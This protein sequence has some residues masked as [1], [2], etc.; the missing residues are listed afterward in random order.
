MEKVITYK[1]TDTG[2]WIAR[3]N[4][5]TNVIELNRREYPRL[6]PM[7]RDYTWIHE[8]VHLA[9]D[10]YD[11]NECNRIADKIFIAR[12]KTEKERRE[13]QEFVANSGGLAR[14]G[15]A[16]SAI[17]GLATTAISLG[18]KI[19]D[20]YQTAKESGYYALNS[21]ER[22][23]LVSGLIKASFEEAK[24]GGRSAQQ[25][26]WSYIVQVEGVGSSYDA[27]INDQANHLARSYIAKCE[28][29]YGFKFDQVL[30]TDW[31][32]KPAVKYSLVI[33]AVAAVV[34]LTLKFIR[35]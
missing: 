10:V 34:L 7:M 27:F 9:Y 28:A 32:A 21:Q 12:A 29:E 5:Q 14:S 17:I 22:Y 25:I 8:Y 11:E 6:S 31:L 13:R 20:Y 18:M 35:K 16:V 3:C 2:H 33:L 24:Q 19:Y 4:H 30:P 1:F 15:I 26:F 23:E